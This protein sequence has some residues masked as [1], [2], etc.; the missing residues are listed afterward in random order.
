MTSLPDPTVGMR[1]LR[2]R[3]SDVIARVRQGESIEVTDHGTPVAR[4]VPIARP[5]RPAV[6]T[7]LE[8]EGRLRRAERPRFVPERLRPVDGDDPSPLTNALLHERENE[9]R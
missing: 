7:R 2:H 5:T 1:E 6:L 8:A 4:I 3:T 9:R